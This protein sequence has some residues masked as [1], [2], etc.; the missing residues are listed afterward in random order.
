MAVIALF[1]WINYRG[2][3]WGGTT[4]D[5][6]TLGAL[7]LLGVFIFGGLVFGK[8]SWQHFVRRIREDTIPWSKVLA[9]PMIAV[10]FTYS[11][12]FASTYVGSEVRDPERN[13]PRSLLWG[14]LIVTVLYTLVN[15]TYLYAVPISKL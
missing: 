8:G 3:R 2:I 4:Q 6:F 10:I 15:I 1:T 12:W 14:T 5:F 11:G 7:A 13:V 9:S